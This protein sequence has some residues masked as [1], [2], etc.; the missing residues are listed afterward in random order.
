[1]KNFIKNTR[2]STKSEAV[3]FVKG[4]KRQLKY[5][6]AIGFH[7]YEVDYWCYQ[8]KYIENKFKLAP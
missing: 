5:W 2:P 1:M 3:R 7:K 8:M 6:N 4:V